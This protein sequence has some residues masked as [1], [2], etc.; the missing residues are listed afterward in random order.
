MVLKTIL[1][2]KLP[3]SNDEAYYWVWGHHPQ[4]SYFD[5]PPAVGWLMWLGTFFENIGNGARLPG[6]WLGHFT[7]LI[8]RKIL[9]PFMNEDALCFWL[10][11]ALFSP[12][13]GIGSL[14]ITPDVPLLFFW[15]LSLLVL[16]KLV[17]HGD[18]RHYAALGA[19]L[20][21]GFCSKYLIVLFVPTSLIWL[22]VSGKWRK[23]RWPLVLITIVVGV[24]FCFPVLW[25]NYKHEWASFLFQLDH[26]L[27]EKNWSISIPLEYL[28]GQILILFPIVAWMALRRRETREASFLHFF[29]WIP[30]AFFFYTSFKARVEANWPLMG[31]P[32]LIALALL[33]APGSKWLKATIAIWAFVLIGLVVEVNQHWIPVDERV[34]KTSEFK[35]FDV[36]MD[37]PAKHEGNFYLGSYQ[38]AATVSYRLRRQIYKLNGANRRDFYDFLPQSMPKGDTFYFGGELYQPLPDWALKAGFIE[39]DRHR[40]NDDFRWVEARRAKDTRQ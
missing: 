37:L 30:L 4:L 8:W 14:V 39:A 10:V 2:I 34:L 24:V 20:G 1:A 33:N 3:M 25:W 32:P 13:F 9:E 18:A 21:L 31:H 28:G 7:L 6:V 40:L 23:I 22:A 35:R 17:D 19:T 16:L 36:F 29:G 12:F 27:K 11:F 26:G 15:S 5:H 38:A